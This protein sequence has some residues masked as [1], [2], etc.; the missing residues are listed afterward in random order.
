MTLDVALIITLAA[1]GAPWWG[2]VGVGILAIPI[3]VSLAIP[4]RR[5]G[6]R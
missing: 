5:R 4:E 1:A 6:T 3:I 2:P